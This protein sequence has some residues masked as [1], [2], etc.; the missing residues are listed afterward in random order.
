[1]IISSNVIR[2][3]TRTKRSRTINIDSD[4]E[5]A[6]D[7]SNKKPNG[8]SVINNTNSSSSS[9]NNNTNS[10]GKHTNGFAHHINDNDDNTKPTKAAGKSKGKGKASAKSKSKATTKRKSTT[11]KKKA[12]TSSSDDSNDDSNNNSDTDNDS[13]VVS[14]SSSSSN[15]SK[16]TNGM[17]RRL[18]AMGRLAL[19]VDDD[20]DG[21]REVYDWVRGFKPATRQQS[22]DAASSSTKKERTIPNLS[23]SGHHVWYSPVDDTLFPPVPPPSCPEDWL[24]TVITLLY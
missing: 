2:R 9:S 20:V 14:S 21:A 8:S 13:K 19:Y 23:T 11:K 17:V 15:S 7:V 6:D 1:M 24:A 10:N 4:H 22:I 18:S 12:A 5:D 3:S 16:G